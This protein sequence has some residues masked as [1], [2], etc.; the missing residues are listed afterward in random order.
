MYIVRMDSGPETRIQWA[1]IGRVKFS[2][3]GRT[4]Y[5]DGRVLRSHG[6]PWYYDTET[7]E[8]FSIHPAPRRFKY[9][10]SIPA[11]VDEDVQVEFWT[12]IRE[13]P[14]ALTNASSAVTTDACRFRPITST[15][16]SAGARSRAP[17]R[18]RERAYD[19][20]NSGSPVHVRSGGASG[21]LV[22]RRDRSDHGLDAPPSDPLPSRP[23]R[24]MVEGKPVVLHLSGDAHRRRCRRCGRP[25]VDVFRPPLGR[26]RSRRGLCAPVPHPLASDA[27]LSQ[28]PWHRAPPGASERSLA[29]LGAARPLSLWTRREHVR[30]R[31]VRSRLTTDAGIRLAHLRALRCAAQHASVQDGS[32]D[33]TSHELVPKPSRIETNLVLAYLL[34]RGAGLPTRA[35]D[36]RRQFGANRGLKLQRRTSEGLAR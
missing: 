16:R 27:P 24:Q 2:K 28:T 12:T 17:P 25:R 6:Q 20:T 26:R 18:L 10:S 3:T 9:P 7:G 21:A 13:E 1:R 36:S 22:R 33:G 19:R 30:R 5:Y 32:T 14:E 23:H 11:E 31:W 34:R 8:S 35:R 15:G 29:V 4:L